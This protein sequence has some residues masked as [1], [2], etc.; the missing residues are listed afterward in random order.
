[1]LIYIAQK[2]FQTSSKRRAS[3]LVLTAQLGPMWAANDLDMCC[4]MQDMQRPLYM[5]PRDA[6]EYGI[7]DKVLKPGSDEKVMHLC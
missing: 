1:M 7:I 2:L 3:A 5:T 4:K 6:M